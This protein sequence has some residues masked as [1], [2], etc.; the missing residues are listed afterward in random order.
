M[1]NLGKLAG[2]YGKGGKLNP[3]RGFAVQP[4]YLKYIGIKYPGAL[5]TFATCLSDT[6]YVGGY[7]VTTLFG[8]KQTWIFIYG[9][10]LY[11]LY[12]DHKGPAG[13]DELLGI[14]DS[15]EGVGFYEDA[16]S[17]LQPFELKWR[18]NKFVAL[19]PP[20]ATSSVA[21][22]INNKGNMA[23]WLLTKSGSAESWVLINGLY[24]EFSYP[25][26]ASTEARSINW[27]N[28][29]AGEYVDASGGIHG[30][31]VTNPNLPLRR[32]WQKI[33]EPDADG[34]TVVTSINL[35]HDI[36]GTYKDSRG[37]YHG[38]IGTAPNP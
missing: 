10:G 12:R 17:N 18:Q 9:H 1:N 33:D 27:E 6:R 28:Q 7:F 38:F 32:T 31:V 15:Y 34:Y 5:D 23:G 21:S 29:V 24:T 2:Y 3:I 37:K 26:A 16:Y 20:R 8:G 25:K 22:G 13:L 4:P 14:N 19:H 11:N 30:F 35:H 36:A